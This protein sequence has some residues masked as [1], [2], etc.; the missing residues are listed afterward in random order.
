MVRLWSEN[1]PSASTRI[2]SDRRENVTT[3]KL[4]PTPHPKNSLFQLFPAFSHARRF[5]AAKTN[6]LYGFRQD[7]TKGTFSRSTNGTRLPRPNVHI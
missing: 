3:L 1:L 2:P 6:C 7:Y 5:F 4:P